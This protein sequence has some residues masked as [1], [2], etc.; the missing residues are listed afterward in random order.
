MKK[1]NL[2]IIQRKRENRNFQDTAEKSEDF[3]I[4]LYVINGFCAVIGVI[5]ILTSTWRYG[6]GITP[7]SVHY[8]SAADSLAA[9][10][11]YI[12]FD[13]T[14]YNHWP[15]LFP[16]LMAL[17][18]LIGIE[19]YSAGKFINAFGFGGIIFSSGILFY[20][21]IK[22]FWLTISGIVAVLLS[23][24]LFKDCT[25]LWSEPIFIVLIIMFIY[26]ITEYLE[27]KQLR[28]LLWAAVFTALACIE[29]YAGLTAIITGSILILFLNRK[30]SL[31]TR[32]KHT[33]L[34]GTISIF[35][36]FIWIIRNRLVSN[37]NIG[38]KFGLLP[39]LMSWIVTRPLE[40]VTAWFVTRNLQ[41]STR[42]IIIGFFIF[43]LIIAKILWQYKTIIP[44]PNTIIA[45]I[46]GIFCLVYA[47]FTIT[48]AI[49]VAEANERLWSVLFVF[50]IL[51][52]L[53]GI[54]AI[55]NFLNR[56]IKNSSAS[57][58]FLSGIM[59]IWLFF[60]CLPI[61]HQMTSFYHDYGVPGA[62]SSFR[63]NAP[64]TIWLKNHRL[65]GVFF[66]NDPE[67][68]FFLQRIR[69]KYSPRKDDKT[70]FRK[71]LSSEKTNYLIWYSLDYYH[72]SRFSRSYLYDLKDISSKYQLKPII[73]LQ[74]GG[75]FIIE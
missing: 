56:L 30:I 13:G 63:Q 26:C 33:I 4:L 47:I 17:F 24:P 32:F 2:K 35:P 72:F 42:L 6:P 37:S 45:K 69:S 71:K 23:I 48:A 46:S 66:T 52:M 9:G 20:R 25:N 44:K 10:K 3:R 68:T 21:R 55:A 62:G 16:S 49:V 64:L 39:D 29:R 28:L 15:P 7:D 57:N 36:L 53:I 73:L 14:P 40:D 67:A 58:F 54:E 31:L 41:L 59:S 60:Y 12:D 65:D 27:K 74:D 19:P 1:R 75:I 11:G 38:Y 70:E 8:L 22:S 5:I 43:I 34:F 50:F 51:L 61:I 18:S